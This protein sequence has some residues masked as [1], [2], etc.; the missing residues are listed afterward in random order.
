MLIAVGALAGAC[1]GDGSASTTTTSVPATTT[2]E[3]PRVNDGVLTLG[4]L[5]P[6][7]GDGAAIG[8]PLAAAVG[9]A[10]DEINSAGGVNGNPVGVVVA[11]EGSTVESATEAI[12]TLL[13]EGVDAVIGPASSNIALATLDQLT[14][15]GV[16][17]C[18]PTASA[19]ALDGFPDEGLFFRTMPSD[20]LQAEAM[21][22]LASRT[23]A[24]TAAIAFLDDAYGRPLAEATVDALARRGLSD[25]VQ[26]PF[27]SGD[28]TLVDDAG[29]LNDSSPDVI[30]IIADADSGTRMLTAI[31]DDAELLGAPAPPDVIVNDAM[32]RPPAA[33]AI[34][35][36]APT[37]REKVQGVSAQ[38]LPVN[39]DEPPGPFATNA[40]DCANIIALGAAQSRTDGPRSIA[41]ELT[42][43]T[44]E[45]SPCRSFAT[46]S[47][48]LE[49]RNIDYDGPSGVL[50][51]SAD[52]SPSQARFD[53]FG[54]DE[55]GVD[56]TTSS[57]VAP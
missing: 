54:F 53:V 7:T 14:A 5:L 44:V 20:S 28:D 43:L 48:L 3:L 17:T 40:Y 11:D 30:L 57:F 16:L 50:R 1:T 56:T 6:A 38:A 45:G 42:A 55:A 10:V 2:A 12:T 31:G 49:T 36:L 34:A 35:D 52:G 21:A 23:G 18:S 41:A 47:S 15:A 13:D 9:R 22:Q 39:E 24:R 8:Q 33:Q 26:V 37:V 29:E 4:A 32:R 27:A 46:C 25:V 19:L 51:L